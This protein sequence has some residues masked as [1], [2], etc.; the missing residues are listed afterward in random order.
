LLLPGTDRKAHGD[1]AGFMTGTG[2]IIDG[3][4]TAH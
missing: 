4:S 1:D 2:F 3:A